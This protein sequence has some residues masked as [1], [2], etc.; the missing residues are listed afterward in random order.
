MGAVEP[1]ATI[2]IGDLCIF[3]L[4]YE[5]VCE[6]CLNVH[7]YILANTERAKEILLGR[8]KCERCGKEHGASI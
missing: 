4:Y 7:R 2:D 8:H 6:N 1:R 5:W 3:P